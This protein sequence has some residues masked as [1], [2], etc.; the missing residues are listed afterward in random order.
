[1]AQV[2]AETAREC[3]RKGVEADPEQNC[4]LVKWYIEFDEVKA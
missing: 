2:E 3:I 1:L 4:L